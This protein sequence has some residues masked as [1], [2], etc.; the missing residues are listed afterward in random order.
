MRIAF[1]R[2]GVEH[3]LRLAK[4]KAG[5]GHFEG[6]SHEELMRHMTLCQLVLP[7]AADQTG[8]LRGE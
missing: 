4:T 6:R 7:F 8:R 5:F 3:V 2:A 1:T